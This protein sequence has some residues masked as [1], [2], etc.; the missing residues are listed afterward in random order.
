MQ[1]AEDQVRAEE[2]HL[3]C[4]SFPPEELQCK[5]FS[6]PLELQCVCRV[7]HVTHS[8]SPFCVFSALERH[9]P[10][11]GQRGTRP[12]TLLAGAALPALLS[13]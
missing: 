10:Q 2:L 8:I 13:C 7:G 6:P 3:K 11:G 4:F 9:Q 1:E 5:C 12:P